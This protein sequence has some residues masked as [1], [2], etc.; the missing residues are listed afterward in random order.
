MDA[1]PV[2]KRA[3]GALSDQ[4]GGLDTAKVAGLLVIGSL[5]VL[6][7]MRRSFGGVQVRLGD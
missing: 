3:M 4:F 7:C 5:V 2:D 1:A 6:G